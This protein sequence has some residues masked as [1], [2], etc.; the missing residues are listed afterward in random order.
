MR[1]CKNCIHKVPVR[2]DDGTWGAECE[3]WDCKFIS[4]KE[5]L[6]AYKEKNGG[7]N[8]GK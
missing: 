3:T 5:C 8:N 6:E 2:N 7:L 1:D 4:R